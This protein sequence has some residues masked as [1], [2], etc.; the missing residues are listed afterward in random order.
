MKTL[1]EMLQYKRPS[2]SVTER[3]FCKRFLEP[4]F[5][6]AY[7]DF[8]NYVLSVGD[9]PTIAFTAHYD[10]VHAEEGMQKVVIED[11]KISAVDS[12]CLGADCTT[13]IYIILEMIKANIPGVY[14]IFAAE[15]VGC[16][17]SSY[18]RD[19]HPEFLDK[20]SAMISFDRFGET[21][22]ITHQ[23]GFRTASDAFANSLSDALNMP[24]LVPDTRGSYTDSNEFADIIPECTNLSVGYLNQHSSKETQD[25]TYL[26]FLMGQIMRAEWGL[27]V[28]PRTPEADTLWSNQFY[29]DDERDELDNMEQIVYENTSL[30]AQLLMDYGLKST[31][32]IEDLGLEDSQYLNRYTG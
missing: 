24:Q 29:T 20:L 8:G 18:M 25:L 27:L 7:D 14:I 13:G 28:F 31:D 4:V 22:V 19:Q 12:N 10:T 2:G 32:L 3:R 5:G 11:G 16:K 30:V 26:K 6:K 17:G 9:D 1:L 23:M 15:E 21:S